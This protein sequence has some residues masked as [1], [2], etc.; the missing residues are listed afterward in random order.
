MF[1]FLLLLLR[2]VSDSLI[3]EDFR[4]KQYNGQNSEIGEKLNFQLLTIM[5]IIDDSIKKNPINCTVPSLGRQLQKLKIMKTLKGVLG[6][7]PPKP[8]LPNC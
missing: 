5:Y 8:T 4:V 1:F 3:L 7:V 2:H 6:S